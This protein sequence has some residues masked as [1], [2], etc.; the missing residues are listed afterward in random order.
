MIDIKVDRQVVKV[1]IYEMTIEW[2]GQFWQYSTVDDMLADLE[3][4][5]KNHTVC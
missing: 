3:T 5:C 4:I 1:N 2:K